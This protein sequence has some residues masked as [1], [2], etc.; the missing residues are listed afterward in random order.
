[1]HVPAAPLALALLAVLP[2][3]RAEG[4]TPISVYVTSSLEGEKGLGRVFSSASKGDVGASANDVQDLLRRRRWLRTEASKDA[5]VVVTVESRER[6]ER[7]RSTDKEGKESIDHRYKL[8]GTVDVGG[9]RMPVR[10]EHDFTETEYSTRD[11][12]DQFRKVAEKFVA[13]ASNVILQSLNDL[14]PDRPEAGF[15]HAA[16]YKL[17]VKGDGLEVRSVDPGSPAEQAGLQVKDRIRQIDSEKGTDQMSER[18]RTWWVE[19]PGTAVM[20]DVERNKQRQSVRLTL[21]P[22][23]QWGGSAPVAARPPAPRGT[24]AVPTSAA[25]AAPASPSGRTGNQ[26]QLRPGMTEAEVLK[27]LGQ[28]REKVGFGAKMLWRYD[29][30][31]LTFENGRVTDMK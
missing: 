17:L 3:A 30:Y 26:V 9:R 8:Y 4:S 23:S 31:S 13:E 29:G 24:A 6:I 16:K 7:R 15:D 2:L 28:P 12:A 1:M 27:A 5:E 10:I 25:A 20:L 21:L 14:R 11:D 22:R 19:E 18:A